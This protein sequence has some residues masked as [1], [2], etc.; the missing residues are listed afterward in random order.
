MVILLKRG[1]VQR[2]REREMDR[3][4]ASFVWRP[5]MCKDRDQEKVERN[6]MDGDALSARMSSALKEG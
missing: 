4:R 3:V 6:G 2:E 5:L 1:T